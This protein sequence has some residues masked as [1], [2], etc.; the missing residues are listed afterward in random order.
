MSGCECKRDS[1]QPSSIG[2]IM[3]RQMILA[4]LKAR[5]VRTIVSILAVALEVTLILVVVGLTT[6]MSEETA[7]RTAGVGEILILPAHSSMFVALTNNTM[8]LKLTGEIAKVP[9]VK[10]VA[11]VQV[12]LN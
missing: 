8:S 6:G 4:G 10:A 3:T 11:A 1:A 9:N 2:R 12:Q 7:N 5:P